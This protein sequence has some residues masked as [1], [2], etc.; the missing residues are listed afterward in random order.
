MSTM[1]KAPSAEAQESY[2]ELAQKL[3]ALRAEL[4]KE[5]AELS[6]VI[7]MAG[8]GMLVGTGQPYEKQIARAAQMRL[9]I[10][11]LELGIMYIEG[12]IGLL[13]RSNYGLSKR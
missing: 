6:A 1:I 4:G 7:S 2:D 9:Q 13:E 12:Q 10:E 3:A 5:S 11:A 8:I